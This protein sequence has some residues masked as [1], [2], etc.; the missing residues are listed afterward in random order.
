[1]GTQSFATVTKTRSTRSRVGDFVCFLGLRSELK[2][3]GGRAASPIARAPLRS[4]VRWTPYTGRPDRD[5]AVRVPQRLERTIGVVAAE[6]AA[7]ARHLG[8]SKGART[9]GTESNPGNR[10]TLCK[11]RL[12]FRVRLSK[13]LFACWK[14]AKPPV[15]QG[16]NPHSL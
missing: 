8:S 10:C 14:S 13:Q 7:Q 2:R 3:A 11:R 6:A 1:M 9:I 16:S 4:K 5:C 12:A 15:N